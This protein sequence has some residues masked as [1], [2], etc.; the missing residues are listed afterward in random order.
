MKENGFPERLKALLQQKQLTLAQVAKGIGTS[1]PSVHRWTRGGEIEY[2]NLRT[3]ADFL[4][5][6]WVWLRYGE[7]AI[8]DLQDTLPANGA[9][10][11]LRRKY[12]GQIM[13]SEARMNLAQE[14]A[15]IVTWEWNVLTGELT[16]SP[17]A[18]QIFGSPLE[19]V[20]PQLL[21]FETLPLA[22]LL[23]QYEHHNQPHERDFSLPPHGGAEERWFASRSQLQFDPQ[24]RPC[25]IVG[26]C[27]DVTQRKHMEAALE[28]SEYLM[29]KIIEI[30]P[31][32]LWIADHNGRITT[33]NPEAERIW[34]GAKFV[35]LEHYG[36]YQGWWE[37]SGE[38]VGSDGWTLARA[39]REG[40]ASRGEIVN[41][42]A[43]DGKRR[44]IIM[45][46]IPLLDVNNAII[47]A[48]EVNQ[49]ITEL[50]QAENK[51]GM[52]VENWHTIFEQPLLGIAYFSSH[53]TGL[54]ANHR[55]CELLERSAENLASETPDKL[56]DQETNGVLAQRITA[57]Q[58]GTTATFE[59]QARTRSGHN[60]QLL[61]LRDGARTGIHTLLFAIR[62]A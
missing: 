55:F 22:E 56:L 29:R 41:I 50:K 52:N 9:M 34:G 12:L 1:A 2:A 8:N 30:I 19:A 23:A 10:S 24:Q 49:D 37:S 39:V 21:P 20:R 53:E 17:N 60:I 54:Q 16:A 14:M 58:L 38:K 57:A 11:D 47:G 62:V 28:R 42:E 32:G 15:H 46:A 13:A 40:E 7:D 48:I 35:D 51:L 33:A 6:N 5:V 18:A 43:F 44:T 31:V 27:I 59:L 25:S 61:C 3:L 45:S 26:V 36:E 4:D